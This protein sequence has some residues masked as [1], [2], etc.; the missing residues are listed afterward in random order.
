M[1]RPSWRDVGGRCSATTD[2]LQTDTQ[3]GVAITWTQRPPVLS[4]GVSE[5]DAD[6]PMNLQGRSDLFLSF[7]SPSFSS[8]T[9]PPFPSLPPFFF[10]LLSPFR[11]PS[12]ASPFLPPIPS[13]LIAPFSH[14]SPLL[15]SWYWNITVLYLLHAML[16]TID[17]SR[18]YSS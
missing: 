16:Y 9:F 11:F 5:I 7:P 2:D 13:P 10:S 14:P 18:V 8:L 17:T 12:Y 1:S 4:W 3:H 15:K 6:R